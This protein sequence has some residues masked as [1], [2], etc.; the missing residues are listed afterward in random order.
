[1]PPKRTAFQVD[2]KVAL[3]VQHTQF[4]HQSQKEPA[5][6]FE[7]QFGKAITQGTVSQ[8]EGLKQQSFD[9]YFVVSRDHSI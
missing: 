6:W 7:A 4:P 2:E 8:T 9:K 3:R 1:M 5:Q